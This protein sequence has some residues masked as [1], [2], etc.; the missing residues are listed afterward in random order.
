MN[1]PAISVILPV[2]NAEKYVALAIQSVLDQSFQDFELI[3]INDG[4]TDT[5]LG[6]IQKFS[7][8]R[9]KLIN[10]ENQGLIKTLNTGI[11]L[12][13][14]NYIARID[15]DDIWSD[16][17]KLA[18]QMEYLSQHIEC[19]VLGTGA[20]IIDEN[21]KEISSLHYPTSDTEIRSQLLISNCFIH[22]SVIFNKEICLK[23]GGFNPNE[24]HVEDY[25]LWLRM[26]LQG[27]LA[28]LPQELMSY[29]IHAS[30]V[31]QQK[32]L[33]QSKNCLELIKR[34]KQ[35]YPNYSKGTWK[36]RMKIFLLQTIGLK[37]LN[38]LKTFEKIIIR[39]YSILF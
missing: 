1:K 24:K 20:K 33:I 30:S 27:T 34:Y 22:P 32:N 11:A 13:Q 38:K 7:D 12:A 17:D 4:S 19:V 36:W 31:T 3:I 25:G 18:R 29:R 28:N 14:S 23:V 35:D 5:S 21:G 2:Y 39:Q 10:Q 16:Q 26:G 15:A 8:P 37:N 9:I 6:S